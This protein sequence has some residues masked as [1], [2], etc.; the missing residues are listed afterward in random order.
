MYFLFHSVPLTAPFQCWDS[1]EPP[2]PG[3]TQPQAIL[4]VCPHHSPESSLTLLQALETTS[5]SWPLVQNFPQKVVYFIFMC[6]DLYKKGD[7]STLNVMSWKKSSLVASSAITAS[8]TL[9]AK[10]N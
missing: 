10:N 7:S 3:V 1:P 5:S 9:I 8:I 6:Q 4:L 2:H